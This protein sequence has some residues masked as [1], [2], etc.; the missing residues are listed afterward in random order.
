MKT[1]I[2]KTFLLI[3]LTVV[4]IICINSLQTVYGSNQE[5][6][7]VLVILGD[8]IAYGTAGIVNP[9]LPQLAGGQSYADI[10]ANTKGWNVINRAR[11]SGRTRGVSDRDMIELLTEDTE[12]A[13]ATQADVAKADIINISIGG[14]DLQGINN[15]NQ[16]GFSFGENFLQEAVNEA[17]AKIDDPNLETPKIDYLIEYLMNNVDEIITAIRE[18]NSDALIVWFSNY[19]PPYHVA[20]GMLA[21]GVNMMFGVSPQA[22]FDASNYIIDRLNEGYKDF[23]ANNPNSFIISDANSAFNGNPALFNGGDYSAINADIIHPNAVGHAV[24][25]AIL[26]A[27][28]NEYQHY[29]L[30]NQNNNLA[31]E[32]DD[33]RNQ[34]NDLT[35]KNNSL[36]DENS[37]LNGQNNNL[38]NENGNLTEQNS[39][40]QGQ[41]TYLMSQIQRLLGANDLLVIFLSITG[42]LLVISL[43]I[44]GFLV[45]QKKKSH[46]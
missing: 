24:L 44:T 46:N 25:A 4:S 13:L 20:T 9:A 11:N 36:N 5:D 2:Q 41:N 14:N 38:S 28:I 26:M 18:L 7:T 22:A 37:N 42:A 27:T 10:I 40:L 29:L 15:T 23:I 1:I 21:V 30:L 16:A 39:T 35:D 3:L 8:S 31:S 34:N 43:G 33:L 17:L 6:E 45:Y 19:V 32:N 12:R